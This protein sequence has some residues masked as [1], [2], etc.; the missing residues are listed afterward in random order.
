MK[1]F[2]KSIWSF[3]FFRTPEEKIDELNC[4]I[5]SKKKRLEKL[6]IFETS[7]TY[8]FGLCREIVN[9]EEEIA[10]LEAKKEILQRNRERVAKEIL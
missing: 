1:N 9:L 4:K 8:V 10:Y 7:G 5:A 6:W 3:L 2:L